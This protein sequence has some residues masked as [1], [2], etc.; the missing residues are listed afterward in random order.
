M[1]NFDNIEYLKTGNFRQ[2]QAYEVLSKSRVMESLHEFDPVLVGTIP[3]DIDIENSDLDIICYWTDRNNFI[4]NIIRLFADKQ[5]FCIKNDQSQNCV[6]ARFT[7]GHFEIEIFGQ[8]IPVKMQMGYRHMIIEYQL[9]LKNG[10]AFRAKII[11]LK[12]QGY[13]TEP[14]FALLLELKGN[15]YEALLKFESPQTTTNSFIK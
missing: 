4:E 7:V 15:P 14:A 13:K 12:K 3:I 9:L 6:I 8:N 1:I 2:K 11:E 10:A 5:G